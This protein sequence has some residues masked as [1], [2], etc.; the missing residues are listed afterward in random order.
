MNG[1]TENSL[2]GGGKKEEVAHEVNS[3]DS[4]GLEVTSWPS[5]KPIHEVKSELLEGEI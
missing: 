4:H 5:K 1:E 3:L 2:D